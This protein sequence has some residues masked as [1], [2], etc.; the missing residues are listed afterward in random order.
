MTELSDNTT[1]DRYEILGILDSKASALLA[2]NAL[3]LAMLAVWLNYI[4]LNVAHLI[5]DAIFIAIVYSSV[6]LLRVIDLKWFTSE[7]FLND[8]WDELRQ[9]RTSKYQRA[10]QISL[11]CAVS[12]LLLTI[13]HMVGTFTVASGVGS[14]TL[15]FLTDPALFGN[16]DR[17]ESTGCDCV[18]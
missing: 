5:L 2:F 16:F 3:F 6:I 18:R 10:R 11:C 4:P 14:E 17:S 1:R 12:I 8:D 15:G 13:A 9:T 7:P